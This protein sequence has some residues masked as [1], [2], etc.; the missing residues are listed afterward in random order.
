MEEEAEGVAG[1][2][3]WNPENT[4][5]NTALYLNRPVLLAVKPPDSIPH[6][7][8]DLKNCLGSLF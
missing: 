4:W 2:K 3:V 5:G 7:L 6:L 8:G 1:G